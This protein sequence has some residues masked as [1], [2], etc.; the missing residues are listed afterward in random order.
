MRPKSDRLGEE[1]C[2]RPRFALARGGTTPVVQIN[3]HPIDRATVRDDW[4]RAT[5]AVRGARARAP[6]EH[7]RHVAVICSMPSIGVTARL[8]ALQRMIDLFPDQPTI[9][10][11][12]RARRA[13]GTIVVAAI[14]PMLSHGDPTMAVGDVLAAITN[15]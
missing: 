6:R 14:E 13:V 15:D 9:T 4:L 12:D 3:C 11:I 8:A 5:S 2:D 10:V 7:G 1:P